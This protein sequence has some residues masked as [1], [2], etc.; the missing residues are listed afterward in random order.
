METQSWRKEPRKNYSNDFKLR[1]AV[2]HA[3]FYDIT[4]IA[5]I[6]GYPVQR[7]PVAAVQSERDPQL[8][9]VIAVELKAI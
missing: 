3:V 9:A 1:D 6:R 4:G 2:H 8:I 5:S 7:F